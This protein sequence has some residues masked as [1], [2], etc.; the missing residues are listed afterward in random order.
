M[1]I[2]PAMERRFFNI[3]LY[4][5]AGFFFYM[6]CIMGFVNGVPQVKKWGIMLLFLMPALVALLAGLALR[7][8][9]DWRRDAGVV[10]LSAAAFT[11]FLIFTMVCFL[12]DEEF[13]RMMKPETLALFGDYWSGGGFMLSLAALGIGMLKAK[14]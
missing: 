11:A 10:L 6:V 13:R 8:F 12:A 1:L 7:S 14:P 9:Q 2:S 5:V 4:V 3:L